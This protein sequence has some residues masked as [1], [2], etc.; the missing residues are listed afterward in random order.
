VIDATNQA[1]L[2]SLPEAEGL[3]SFVSFVLA[4]DVVLI[5]D[6]HHPAYY[7]YVEAKGATKGQVYMNK[8]GTAFSA[9]EL[10]AGLVSNMPISLE[11]GNSAQEA[12]EEAIGRVSKKKVKW[13]S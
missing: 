3:D 6:D 9:G 4:G 11:A 1:A 5:G 12:L 7:E 8:K 10:L 2:K 13:R